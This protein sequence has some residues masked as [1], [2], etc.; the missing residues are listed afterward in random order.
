MDWDIDVIEMP[1]PEIRLSLDNLPRILDKLK[2]R[3]VEEV[4]L[5]NFPI[6][7]VLSDLVPNGEVWMLCGGEKVVLRNGG[8]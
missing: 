4:R 2:I 8:F 1:E 6:R 7:I 5:S 3:S